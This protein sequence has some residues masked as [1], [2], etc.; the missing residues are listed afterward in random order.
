MNNLNL[1]TLLAEEHRA[2]LLRQAQRYRRAHDA[3]AESR[4]LPKWA[5]LRWPAAFRGHTPRLVTVREAIP[6]G[7]PETRIRQGPRPPFAQLTD[8]N[9]TARTKA[10]V[11]TPP[12]QAPGALRPPGRAFYPVRR[13]SSW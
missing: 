11:T 2:E 4:R 5:K 12:P 13:R 10:P 3:K 9:A 1:S 7:T 6:L 8:P